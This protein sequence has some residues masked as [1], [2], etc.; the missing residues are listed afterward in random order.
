MTLPLGYEFL[1]TPGR[2]TLLTEE[3]PMI[4]RIFTD[5]RTHSA[6]PEPTY[7]GESIGHW[8]GQIL[9]VDTIAI[10]PKAEF[11]NR[12]K[13]SGKTRVIERFSLLTLRTCVSRSRC[14]IRSPSRARGAT[15]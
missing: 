5:G 14:S 10:N 6:D 2:V 3:G 12:L 4:R 1:F 9:V 7:A 11:P 8:E 15:L 13:T